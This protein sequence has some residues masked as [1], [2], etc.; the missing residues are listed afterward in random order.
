M[1]WQKLSLVCGLL[2]AGLCFHPTDAQ[3]I[4]TYDLRFA[5]GTRTK[6]AQVGTYLTNL[7]AVIDQGGDDTFENES[8]SSGVLSIYSTNT[9]GGAIL[10][11][12]GSGV[13]SRAPVNRINS[14]PGF[15]NPLRVATDNDT[16]GDLQRD[17]NGVAAPNSSLPGVVYNTDGILD[18]GAD[19]RYIISGGGA[20]VAFPSLANYFVG[21]VHIAG[22]TRAYNWRFIQPYSLDNLSPNDYSRPSQVR[23]NSWEVLIGQFTITINGVTPGG[24]TAFTPFAYHRNRLTSTSPTPAP[25][26]TYSQD[27]NLP[28]HNPG[29]VNVPF[30]P[31]SFTGVEFIPEPSAY[32][33]GGLALALGWL[34]RKSRK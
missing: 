25:G 1:S 30:L 27:G 10:P 4:L 21:G 6:P 15:P 34:F 8:I 29:G 14:T 18:W 23:P 17:N 33:C 26:V 2:A 7:Y 16:T 3:A 24:T 32:F 11:G 5:D 22:M 19:E 13:T 9:G 31:G 12:T 28:T 20:N